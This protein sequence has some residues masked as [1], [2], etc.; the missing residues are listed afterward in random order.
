MPGAAGAQT[1]DIRT[2][3]IGGEPVEY[4]LVLPP[5]FSSD[6]SYPAILAFPPGSQAREMVDFSVAN[7]WG[8]E[9]QSRG[10]VVFIPQAPGGDWFFEAGDRVFPELIDHF[11]TSYPVDPERFHVAGP[12]NGGRSALHVAMA[13][14]ER[15]ASVTVFPGYVPDTGEDQLNSPPV[16]DGQRLTRLTG[17]CIRMF[18]GERDDPW[19]ELMEPQAALMAEVGLDV[20]LQV[21]AGEGHL[22]GS[23]VRENA[24]R[25][26]DSIE[27]CGS[28]R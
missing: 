22:P 18:V 14:P 1:V 16:R 28:D 11:S 15:F 10:Y 4:A 5:G 2:V 12:S 17:L 26:F 27:N 8:S 25:L 21:E 20:S 3:D 19:R 24:F 7:I 23:L 13:Y 9:A 6:R